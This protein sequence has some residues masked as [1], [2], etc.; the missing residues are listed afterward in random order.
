MLA[1]LHGPARASGPAYANASTAFSNFHVSLVDLDPDDGIAPSVQFFS[2]AQTQLTAYDSPVFPAAYDFKMLDGSWVG[3]WQ[4][5]TASVP[6]AVASSTGD[7]LTAQ[8]SLDVDLLHGDG[9]SLSGS[10]HALIG[11]AWSPEPGRFELSPHTALVLE[12]TFVSEAHLD[13]ASLA[14]H[15]WLAG[16]T[17]W[18]LMAEASARGDLL[19]Y[20]AGSYQV[21]GEARLNNSVRGTWVEG[22][23]PMVGRDP[24]GGAPSMSNTFVMRIEN[25]GAS[26]L[27]ALIALT[28]LSSVQIQA[29]TPAV[30]EP[31]AVLAAL[32]GLGTV[33][34]ARRRSRRSVA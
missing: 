29:N 9:H 5:A 27:E 4:T 19:V 8:A 14:Q 32:A 2:G 26:S 17:G 13:L 6:G 7:G 28:L 21:L 16:N 20:E 18:G 11:S 30:P 31:G 22:G 15:A 34:V 3:G 10:N 24:Q 23:L 25:T 12:G 33:L 1:L